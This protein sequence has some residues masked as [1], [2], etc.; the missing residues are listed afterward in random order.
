MSLRFIAGS[1]GS[2]KSY[3][4]FNEI[5]QRSL[6][7]KEERFFF[8]VPDQFTMQTQKE[9]VRLHPAHSIMN[10]DVLS[11]NRLAAHVFDETGFNAGT[12]LEDMG[13]T[14]LLQKVVWDKRRFL[15]VLAKTLDRPGGIEKMKSLVSELM[16]YRVTPEDLTEYS[17]EDGVSP[18]LSAKLSE[19]GLI[20]DA[21][22]EKIKGRYLAAE[23][24]CEAL[25]KMLPESELLNGSTVI[26]DGFT[27]FVPTQ[28]LVI[29]EILRKAKEVIVIITADEKAGLIR[30]SSPANL[31]HMSHETAEKLIDI[32][33]EE[34]IEVTGPEFTDPSGGRFKDSEAIAFLEKELFRY[35]GKKYSGEQNDIRI[36]RAGGT[37]DEIAAAAALISRLVRTEGFKYRDF[38]II[39]SDIRLYGRKLRR[40]LD[41]CGIPCFL[42]EKQSVMANPCVSFLRGAAAMID[43][44]FSYDSVFTYLRSGLSGLTVGE[45]DRMENYVLAAGIRGLK[46]YTSVWTKIPENTDADMLEELNILRVR[47]TEEISGLT[48]V[49]KTRMSAVGAKTE[50][51]YRLCE[52]CRVQEKLKALEEGFKLGKDKLREREYA[53]IYK[54]VMDLFDKM[55][56]ILGEEKIGTAAYRRLLETGLSQLRIG[57]IP[58]GPDEVFIGDIE[59]SR[60]KNIKVLIFA[61]LNDGLVPR[62]AKDPGLINESDREALA[63]KGLALSPSAKDEMFRQ[64]FYLYTC[65]TLASE[66]IFLTFRKTDE[67]FSGVMPSYLIDEIAGMF[68]AIRTEDTDSPEF[69]GL[70]LETAPGRRAV[71]KDLMEKASSEENRGSLFE[72]FRRIRQDGGENNAAE[73]M[74][75]GLSLRNTGAG[76]CADTAEKI[77]KDS[78][79]VTRLQLFASCAFA[80]FCRY[81]LKLNEREV[82][83]FGSTDIGG[84]FHSVLKNFFTM[85][86]EAGGVCRLSAEERDELTDRALDRTLGSWPDTVMLESS[87]NRAQVES[88][89]R[90]LHITTEVLQKQLAAGEFETV[91]KEADYRL[92]KL[93]GTIDRYDICRIGDT[94]YI[95]VID[96]KS[97]TSSIDYTKMFYGLQIQLPVY[98]NAA[99]DIEGKN[100]EAKAAGIYYLSIKA[101][102]IPVDSMDDQVS[103]NEFLKEMRFDG[104][105]LDDINVIGK[106]D[107]DPAGSTIIPVRVKKN[108]ELYRKTPVA[109]EGDFRLIERYINKL[110]EDMEEA[111]MNGC[112]SIEP[113]VKDAEDEGYCAYCAYKEV[114]GFDGRIPGF[115]KK[116]LNKY[117][118]ETVC[119][120]MSEALAKNGTQG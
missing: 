61:G 99:L 60:I 62:R 3:R 43:E 34:N 115:R 58:T 66:K 52:R 91:G 109:S 103:Y 56:S 117:S 53:G 7:D 12:I 71:L 10:I 23:E 113:A 83:E 21:L 37:D 45:I 59:R 47:F 111:I 101:P 96:Y 87:R 105:T 57:M 1:S 42:D 75:K 36:I 104:L 28:L 118:R 114:C 40:Y 93:K 106:M 92:G 100:S 68:P 15:P 97:G 67:K 35:T 19:A 4:I 44:D 65:L 33:R 120:A 102:L 14:L 90:I 86:D 48:E 84:I 82:Y 119:Q 9:L 39:V 17:G 77:Y 95:R 31:F 49:F 26:F 13:K 27:G 6:A 81:G 79:S 55:V 41:D 73:S 2:G 70:F 78:Y 85:A 76:I 74:I 112:A 64:R 8:M 107:A 24:V 108:G 22:K 110:A 46:K 72:L 11:F 69:S 18:L 25:S 51:L 88:M 89:R 29:R 80:H 32:A 5:I 20:Y 116:T 16:Q 50:A 98:L 63:E 94:A 54:A 30:K 38:A